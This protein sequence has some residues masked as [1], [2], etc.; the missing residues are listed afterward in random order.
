MRCTCP[1]GSKGLLLRQLAGPRAEAQTLRSHAH[2]PTAHNHHPACIICIVKPAVQTLQQAQNRQ[3][4]SSPFSFL[5]CSRDIRLT[6]MCIEVL[7]TV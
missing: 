4:V 7:H 6:V 5:G 3:Y 2:S 1:H